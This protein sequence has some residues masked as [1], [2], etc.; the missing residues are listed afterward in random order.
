MDDCPT[1]VEQMLADEGREDEKQA[2]LAYYNKNISAWNP[3]S[4]SAEDIARYKRE[5]PNHPQLANPTI[6]TPTATRNPCQIRYG[7]SDDPANDTSQVINAT[8][9]H[10]S[11]A[12]SPPV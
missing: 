8:N 1:N 11:S 2:L 10:R 3:G 4:I 7:E 5:Q 9:R 12:A 6:I